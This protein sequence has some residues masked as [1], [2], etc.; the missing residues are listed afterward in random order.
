MALKISEDE[1]LQ[2]P[3]DLLRSLREYLN[4]QRGLGQKS[5]SNITPP[6]SSTPTLSRVEPENLEVYLDGW[7]PEGTEGLVL[8]EVKYKSSGKHFGLRV[9]QRVGAE[10]HEYCAR[11]WRLTPEVKTIVLSAIRY[12]FDKLWRQGHPQTAYCKVQRSGGAEVKGPRYDD[13]SPHIG[14]SSSIDAR[15]LFVLGAE[16]RPPDVRVI[17]FEKGRVEDLKKILRTEVEPRTPLLKDAWQWEGRGGNNIF[18]HPEDL[19][20]ILKGIKELQG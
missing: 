3:P 14:F 10:Y 19:E 8:Q 20:K 6:V 5:E 1:L 7:G 2:M 11:N 13:G 18:V 9:S 4:Q 17:T 16:A 12:G 15:W